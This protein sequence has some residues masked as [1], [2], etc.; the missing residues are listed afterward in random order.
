[1]IKL[2]I[3]GTLPDG[4]TPD[5]NQRFWIAGDP[6]KT[7]AEFGG[8]DDESRAISRSS[9]KE[10]GTNFDFQVPIDTG[11]ETFTEPFKTSR[12]FDTALEAWQWCNSFSRLDPTL[13]PHPIQGDCV[14]RFE[15]ADGTFVEERLYDCLVSKPQI[16]RIG[17][18]VNLSYQITGGR[19]EPY[20]TGTVVIPIAFA[21]EP[22]QIKLYATI[23]GGGITDALTLVT[24]S[25]TGTLTTGDLV[26]IQ[27][28]DNNGGPAITKV[29]ELVGGGS[30]APGN[31]AIS[32][33]WA[34]NLAYVAAEYAAETQMSA[35]VVDDGIRPYV[36]ISW[37][38]APIGAEDEV[39][40]TIAVTHGAES[41]EGTTNAE[42]FPATI[43]PVDDNA[44]IPAAD[45]LS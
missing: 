14:E 29:F 34:D 37:L 35:A 15:N 43:I 27:G 17:K 18:T 1:M 38:D 32:T 4:F 33:P 45:L 24:G 9:Q 12:L 7:H 13:W 42:D 21:P 2:R 8:F 41:Y 30:P 44:D 20:A 6:L 16:E 36:L 31:I 23:S 39:R 40:I 10:A 11:N 22:V 25:L 3:M 5:D 19:I 26:Q 28:V